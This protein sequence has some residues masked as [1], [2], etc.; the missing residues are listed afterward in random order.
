MSLYTDVGGY[1]RIPGL[2]KAWQVRLREDP[3]AFHSFEHGTHPDHDERLAAY[4]AEAF[5]GPPLYTAGYGHETSMQRIHACNGEHVELDE[6][7]LDAFDRA[8]ADV[9]LT[10]E[11]ARRVSGYFRRATI[12]HRRYGDPATPVPDG[13][14]F[15]GFSGDHAGAVCERLQIAPDLTRRDGCDDGFDCKSYRCNRPRRRSPG[16]GSCRSV[17]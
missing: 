17:C 12:E 2:C 14:E 6:A 10:G 16:R 3:L 5:G 8:V 1:D 7:C 9:G 13:L 15:P 11:V 4:L